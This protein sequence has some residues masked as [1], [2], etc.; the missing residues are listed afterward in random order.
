MQIL[1]A[2]AG[3]ILGF[4]WFAASAFLHEIALD[5]ANADG[6]RLDAYDWFQISLGPI[7]ALPMMWLD[8]RGLR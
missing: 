5:A 8:E 6:R 3:I 7:A 2:V 4:V 1:L